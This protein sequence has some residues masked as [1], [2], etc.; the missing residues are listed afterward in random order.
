MARRRGLRSEVLL[1]LALLMGTAI[2][3]LGALLL[4]TH[5]SHVRQLHALAARSLLADARSPLQ[6][7]PLS[8]PGMRWWWLDDAGRVTPRSEGA[9]PIDAGSLELALSA[10]CS[11]AGASDSSPSTGWRES[12]TA[13]SITFSSSRT[14]PGNRYVINRS[15]TSSL[16]PCTGLPSSRAYFWMK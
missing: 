8:V 6:E 5:E 15:I 1:S 4:A 16:A 10:G 13:R 7:L 14:L 9:G 3:V 11:T 2:L 12:A